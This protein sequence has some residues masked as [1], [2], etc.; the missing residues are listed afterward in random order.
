MSLPII[1][2]GSCYG[3]L[4]WGGLRFCHRYRPTSGGVMFASRLHTLIPLFLI[5]ILIP[6][7]AQDA[8]PAPKPGSSHLKPNTDEAD[9]VLA[10]LDKR[11][12]GTTVADSDW[13]RLF[14]TEP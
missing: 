12:A 2:K 10:I 14:S 13:Q 5:S 8:Q 1:S 3:F 4:P 11:T 9:A 6:V 7:S